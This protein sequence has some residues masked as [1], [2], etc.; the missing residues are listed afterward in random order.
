MVSNAVDIGQDISVT[1]PDGALNATVNI[2][3]TMNVNVMNTVGVT[4]SVDAN[5]TNVA[6]IS[7][8]PMEN[9]RGVVTWRQD[10]ADNYTDLQIK[11]DTGGFIITTQFT[12][13]VDPALAEG[14]QVVLAGTRWVRLVVDRST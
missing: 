12:P 1:I 13:S 11:T 10:K 7:V 4:G 3:D 2:P 8:Q 9:G 5:V 14:V 6:P